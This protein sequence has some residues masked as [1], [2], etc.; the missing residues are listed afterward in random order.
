MGRQEWRGA[1]TPA[2]G[3]SKA[4]LWPIVE[5]AVGEPVCDFAVSLESEVEGE[6][7]GF[8]AD[9]LVPTFHYTTASRREGRVTVFAKL[10]HEAVDVSESEHYAAMA[11]L[12]AP[13]PHCYGAL[14]LSDADRREVIFL[15]HV[16]PVPDY[17]PYDRF[18]LDEPRFRQFIALTAHLDALVPAPDYASRLPRSSPHDVYGGTVGACRER[19]Q[20]LWQ[21]A[22]V[23]RL[24]D[25]LLALCS[26]N[27][28]QRLDPLLER[29]V[30]LEFPPSD[31]I[32]HDCYEPCHT[33]W[34]R[35]TGE[36]LVLDLAP[37]SLGPRFANI[38][39]WLGQPDEI[40]RR[41]RPAVEL[42]EVYLASWSARGG[43]PVSLEQ[44]E[45][46]AR[47][48]WLCEAVWQ[49]DLWR[50]NVLA[51]ERAYAGQLLNLVRWLAR[52]T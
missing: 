19:F 50:Q 17:R 42:A 13:V 14:P 32:W 8:N 41:C 49:M 21:D 28:V 22:E 26:T 12:G 40:Q 16:R 7:Y 46:E 34:R 45:R 43:E 5:R 38:G 6:H 9:K 44:F 18:V 51:G 24:G 35:G 47:A 11:A 27:P 37:M 36:M 3:L 20:A 29:V 30:T 31:R 52:E 33:G 4:R 1:V 48:L 39:P 15:E 2:V 25:D 10:A 23:G